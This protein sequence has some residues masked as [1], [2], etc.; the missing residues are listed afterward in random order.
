[1]KFKNYSLK[2]KTIE[3]KTFIKHWFT[4]S[5]AYTMGNL[6]VCWYYIDLAHI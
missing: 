6:F 2:T 5:I 4:N 1:M 3:Y